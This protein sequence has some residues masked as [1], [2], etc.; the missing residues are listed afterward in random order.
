[1]RGYV[2]LYLE[3]IA[4]F[5]LPDT[6]LKKAGGNKIAYEMMQIFFPLKIIT[7]PKMNMASADWIILQRKSRSQVHS[8]Y[9][10]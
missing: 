8:K 7:Y 3:S 10:Y 2:F 5:L 9:L 6:V 1:M 4:S